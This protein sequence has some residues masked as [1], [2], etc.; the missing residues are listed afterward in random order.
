M[1]SRLPCS[2]KGQFKSTCWP[3]IFAATADDE[4]SE[5]HAAITSPTVV[6]LRRDNLVLSGKVISIISSLN[7]QARKT[8]NHKQIKIKSL[9]ASPNPYVLLKKGHRNKTTLM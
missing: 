8:S 2:L 1:I 6:P 4:A 5:S 7:F 3:L 9:K